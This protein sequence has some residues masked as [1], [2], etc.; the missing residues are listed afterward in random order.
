M[1]IVNALNCEL[2]FHFNKMSEAKVGI[3]GSLA[4]WLDAAIGSIP[5]FMRSLLAREREEMLLQ[6]GGSES[7]C[8][9][10]CAFADQ[11]TQMNT[12]VEHKENS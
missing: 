11:C 2:F 10:I 9:A 5:S 12:L 3:G 4:M 6:K 8:T 7:R 1:E